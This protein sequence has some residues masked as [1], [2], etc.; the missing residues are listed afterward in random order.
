MQAEHAKERHCDG[1]LIFVGLGLSGSM[2]TLEAIDAISNADTVYLE[3]YTSTPV[4]TILSR[5][6][7]LEKSRGKGKIE[8]L[9][10]RELEEEGGKGVIQRLILGE[11]VAIL[12]YGDPFIATTHNALR[13]EA[14]RLGCRVRYVP[15]ISIFQYSISFV[16]L[17]NYRFGQSVTVV[18]PRWN[19]LYTSSYGIINENL[20]RDLHTFVFLDIDELLGPMKPDM[21]ARVLLESSKEFSGG[22]LNED[23]LIIVLERMGEPDERVY[24]RTLREA[25]EESWANPP[26]SLIVPAS[27]H[28]ME[29]EVLRNIGIGCIDV[30][31]KKTTQLT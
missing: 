27:L 15:G 12:V 5:L 2:M 3:T 23:S 14:A 10:R 16:G 25:S 9:S 7:K 8:R 29:R 28:F 13:A 11:S 20:K 26:Y 19:I 17:S 6:A 30:L 21:A 24:C 31:E 1:E 18:Y 22:L 4:D